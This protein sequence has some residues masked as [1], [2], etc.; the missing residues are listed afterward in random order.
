[1]RGQR[2]LMEG[3]NVFFVGGTEA[4]GAV[5][6]LSEALRPEQELEKECVCVL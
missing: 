3:T 1:M 5:D 2:V 4:A 6:S